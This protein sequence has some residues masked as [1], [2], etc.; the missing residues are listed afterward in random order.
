MKIEDGVLIK[1]EDND[2][3]SEGKCVIPYGVT[4][5]GKQVFMDSNIKSV[6]L[7]NSVTSIEP[8]AFLRCSSLTEIVI[9]DSITDLGR[10]AFCWCNSLKTIK[11]SNNI[12]CINQNVFKGCES[13]S[14]LI[15]PENVTS[16]EI[17]AF[18]ICSS[19]SKVV[20]KGELESVGN[21]A[22]CGCKNLKEIRVQFD[23]S[24]RHLESSYDFPSNCN[25]IVDKL[26]N[27]KENLMLGSALLNDELEES[28]DNDFSDSKNTY[29]RNDR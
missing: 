6:I 5:I 3:D 26:L 15:I 22:F 25:I 27:K 24:K 14:D 11:L 12:T 10:G 20:I 18:S 2:I 28:V 21:Y 19:L 17:Y 9:P 7:P 8:Y 4:T 1:I 13:L 16:I 29:L 23:I